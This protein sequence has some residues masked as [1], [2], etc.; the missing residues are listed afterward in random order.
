MRDDDFEHFRCDRSISLGINLLSIKKVLKC[1]NDD[2]SVTLKSEDNGSQ[3]TLMFESHNQDRISDCEMKLMD[4]DSEHLIIPDTEYKASIK[5]SA[6]EFQRIMRDLSTIGDTI[7]I[8]A[9]KKAVKFSI[10]G[11]IGNCNIVKRHNANVDKEVALSAPLSH[12]LYPSPLSLPPFLPALLPSLPARSPSF[13]SPL[14]FPLSSLPPSRLLFTIFLPSSP[15]L[16]PFAPFPSSLALPLFPLPFTSCFHI[17]ALTA[18]DLSA[19]EQHH[20]RAGGDRVADGGDKHLCLLSHLEN[21]SYWYCW[22]YWQV[23]RQ[24]HS[25]STAHQTIDTRSKTS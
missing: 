2:D 22:G 18:P 24:N 13:P 20:H 9:P 10:E 21:H 15:S 23:I 8:S 6:T 5:M 3:L 19:G 4:I 1:A 11:D 16:Y 7:T 12:S 17:H 25:T 14:S